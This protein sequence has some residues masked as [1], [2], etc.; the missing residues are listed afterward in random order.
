MPSNHSCDSSKWCSSGKELR[1]SLWESLKLVVYNR[2]VILNDSIHL[3]QPI[4]TY[5][6]LFQ[7]ISTYFNLFQPIST[8]FNLFQPISTYFNLFQPI[9]SFQPI[10][11]Y[12]TITPFSPFSPFTVYKEL[13]SSLTP[14]FDENAFM[15]L[16][17]SSFISSH[18]GSG[19]PDSLF[20]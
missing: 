12:L 11:T 10:S 2:C 6:N 18:R 5:F 8:Y 16:V 7:P 1:K 4:S 19:S 15:P 13:R 20:H 17:S 14:E 9:H 3:F